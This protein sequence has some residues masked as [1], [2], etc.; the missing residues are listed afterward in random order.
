MQNYQ[1]SS[2]NPTSGFVIRH[3]MPSVEAGNSSFS[4]FYEVKAD[5]YGKLHELF[6]DTGLISEFYDLE[7]DVDKRAQLQKIRQTQVTQ[8]ILID[9]YHTNDNL[10]SITELEQLQT[11]LPQYTPEIELHVQVVNPT[12]P[13]NAHFGE[14]FSVA[15]TVWSKGTSGY[16]MNIHE[17]LFEGLDVSAAFACGDIARYL[18]ADALVTAY[19]EA[20]QNTLTQDDIEMYKV[21]SYNFV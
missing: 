6:V 12:I 3:C 18:F 10:L 11:Q 19:E 1:K 2:T 16:G 9:H 17:V 13:W 5:S 8:L 7:W 4:I 15:G 21:A 14:G 20:T